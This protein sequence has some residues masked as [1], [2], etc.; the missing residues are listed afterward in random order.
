MEAS[1]T[2]TPEA[3]AERQRELD[4]REASI[5]WREAQWADAPDVPAA[6]YASQPLTRKC[7]KCGVGVAYQISGDEN[8]AIY[9]C[10]ACSFGDSVPNVQADAGLNPGNVSKDNSPDELASVARQYGVNPE[11]Y[12]TKADLLDAIKARTKA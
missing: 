1:V 5:A 3:L 4:E 8:G 11:S 7:R 10:F 6:H 12:D 9:K 2:P